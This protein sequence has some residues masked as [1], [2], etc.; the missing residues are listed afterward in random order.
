MSGWRHLL[1]ILR[2]RRFDRFTSSLTKKAWDLEK[3]I[4]TSGK[5]LLTG[6]I[7]KVFY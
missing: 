1:K 5:P 4:G 3:G 7:R 6:T 2:R